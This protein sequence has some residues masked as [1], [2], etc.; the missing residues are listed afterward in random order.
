MVKGALDDLNDEG[1][2]LD[3]YNQ[4]FIVHV[5]APTKLISSQAYGSGE[6]ISLCS[7]VDYTGMEHEGLLWDPS[8]CSAALPHTRT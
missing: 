6:D 8:F 1:D 3:Y 2:L 7:T 4:A 5:N